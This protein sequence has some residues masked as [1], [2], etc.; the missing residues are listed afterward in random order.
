M[1]NAWTRVHYEVPAERRHCVKPFCI[2]H[3]VRARIVMLADRIRHAFRTP[4]VKWFQSD[5]RMQRWQLR[6]NLTLNVRR[7]C[8]VTF[9]DN[10]WVHAINWPY[11][12]RSLRSAWC[13]SIDPFVFANRAS[14]WTSTGNWPVP[15]IDVNVPR[16]RNVPQTWHAFGVNV[17]IH[18]L[19]MTPGASRHVTRTNSVTWWTTNPFAYAR[20]TVSHPFRFA[21]ETMGVHRILLV[22]TSSA[23]IHVTR[24][25]ALRTPPA[26]W[27]TI[28]Q[29]VN[30]AHPAT[31]KT[32]TRDV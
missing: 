24:P 15:R 25:R 10:A 21:F 4:I 30:S 27:K 13:A 6:A 9:R 16:M 14:W 3:G 7:I 31:L 20:K 17:A 5:R 19:I 1:A 2:G 28:S 8:D 29:F 26:T 32:L 12:V 11:R 23:L 22:A 18:A